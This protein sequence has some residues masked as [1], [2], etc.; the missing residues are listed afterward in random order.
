MGKK[1]LVLIPA[2]FLIVGC[3]QQASSA[4]IEELRKTAM[5]LSKEAKALREESELL[6]KRVDELEKKLNEHI[7]NKQI[8]NY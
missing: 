8:H 1:V 3:A 5:E 2:L 6:R 4:Q 7:S